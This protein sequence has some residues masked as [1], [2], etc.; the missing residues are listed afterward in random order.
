MID[1]LSSKSRF[2]KL[3]VLGTLGGSRR[4]AQGDG[5]KVLNGGT[6]EGLGQEVYLGS[7]RIEVGVQSLSSIFRAASFDP[8]DAVV[9]NPVLE[10]GYT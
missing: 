5:G 10:T 6:A 8:F 1:G 9:L 4:S 2:C 7:K 3:I